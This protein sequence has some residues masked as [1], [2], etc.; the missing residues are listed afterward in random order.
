M[1]ISLQEPSFEPQ[2]VEGCFDDIDAMA[3]SPLAWNLEYEQI[4]RGRFQGQLT[5][6][7]MDQL[8]LARINWSPGVL[9][10]GSAPAGTWVFGLPISAGGS[11]H[12][13][14]RPARAGELL[15][16][17]SLVDVGFT[18]TGPT[19]MMVI[20]LP[21]PM[22]DRW[23]QTRRG[24]DR[25][26]VNLPSPRWQ[27]SAPEM[28]RRAGA[29]SSLLQRLQTQ[30]ISYLR[31]QGLSHVES[32][33]L[34]VVLDMIPSAEVIEPLHSR[35]RVARAV[36]KILHERLDNPPGITE[37]CLAVGAKERT[38]HLSCVEAFGRPPAALLAE[39]R[40]NAA[41][42]ALS[43][44]RE[45]ISVTAVAAHY[46]FA[47]FGRFSEVYRRQFGELPSVT[48]SRTRGV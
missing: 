10:S 17:T 46:G 6:L 29:L 24:I 38:L 39:L 36:L 43:H 28:T 27:V 8:Q 48:L 1:P 9:Q 11:L 4:G 22:I 13:R 7:L 16:A 42:R 35:A 12:V 41:H 14:R 18:A 3:A 21:T 45:W 23:I 40:L 25:F 30:P 33:I 20:V 5:Q 37:L 2:L 47:H 32:R 19:E 44:P 31:G 15:A 34:D 26:D